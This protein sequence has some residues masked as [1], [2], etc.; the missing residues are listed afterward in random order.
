MTDNAVLIT[1]LAALTAGA[2]YAAGRW[3]QWYR[4]GPE[5]DEAYQAGYDTATRS[6]FSMA[7]RLI[8][9]RKAARGTAAVVPAAPAPASPEAAG[10]APSASLRSKAAS[11]SKRP[12]FAPTPRTASVLSSLESAALIS[13]PTPAFGSLSLPVSASSPS[14]ATSPSSASSTSPSAAASPSS[15]SSLSPASPSPASSLSQAASSTSTSTSAGSAAAPYRAT[16]P[17]AAGSPVS[18]R[19]IDT[20]S[21]AA[22]K[23][24][25]APAETDGET[26]A[27][28]HLVPDELVKAPT[29]RLA[30]DRVARAK[31]RE[32]IPPE[33]GEDTTRLPA[34]P[35]PRSS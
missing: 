22:A 14:A 18:P 31:V 15:A 13:P 19:L 17:E 25:E 26:R 32:A 4:T 28:R 21:P 8:G 34:V 2:G 12:G 11:R 1:L 10:P 7:A 9:A 27:G 5:R 3:H 16:A 24:V 35:R 30:P 29:Y 6:V 23:P 20:R 33:E